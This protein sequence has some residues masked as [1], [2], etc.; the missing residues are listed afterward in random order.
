MNLFLIALSGNNYFLNQLKIRQGGRKVLILAFKKLKNKKN[1]N[2]KE[3][4]K[5]RGSVRDYLD[6][7][8]S[9]ELLEDLLSQAAQSSNTGNMQTYSVVVTR[10]EEMKKRLAPLHFNQRM[11]TGA[12]VVLTF[13]ADYNLFTRWCKERNAEP[14]YDNFLSFYCATIDATIWAQTFCVAAEAVGLG[15]CYLGT[16]SYNATEIAEVLGLPEL[17]IPVVTITVGYPKEE[18]KVSDRLPI[19]SLIH[20]EKY[21]EKNVDEAFSYKESLPEMQAYVKENNKETLAQVF[22]DIRYTKKN[23]E[24]FSEKLLD[25]VKNNWSK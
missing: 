18:P 13:C 2:M 22:T 25:L 8:V 16:V 17:V 24:F 3:F 4:L 11:I 19:K 5:N 21:E 10:E 7:E 14:G 15:I 23:N 1:N 20:N 12:P 6:K 9:E